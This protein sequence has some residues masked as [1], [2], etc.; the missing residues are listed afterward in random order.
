MQLRLLEFLRFAARR[1][2]LT[3]DAALAAFEPAT[4]ETDPPVERRRESLSPVT[5]AARR[6][7]SVAT[8]AWPEHRERRAVAPREPPDR[9]LRASIRDERSPARAARGR[10]VTT[11][12]GIEPTACSGLPRMD[13]VTKERAARQLSWE[14][15]LGH[16]QAKLKDCTCMPDNAVR[17]LAQF[18]VVMDARWCVP[19]SRT[20]E[21]ALLGQLSTPLG[22]HHFTT[23]APS[24][25][26]RA[27]SLRRDVR[28][29][30][31][32]VRAASWAS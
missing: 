10:R 1:G 13:D 3:R 7:R 18:Q 20:C 29:P 14:V 17:Q 28:A 5:R 31:A 26:A 32:T 22:P 23:R 24:F 2:P 16:E 21:E 8:R 6:L 4:A 27:P 25:T 9:G 12:K 15:F 30:R 11:S 19:A